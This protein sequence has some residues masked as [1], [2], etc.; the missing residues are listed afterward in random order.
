M[1]QCR[2]AWGAVV[3]KYFTGFNIG[4]PSFITFDYKRVITAHPFYILS[5]SMLSSIVNKT[6]KNLYL[7]MNIVRGESCS[8]FINIISIY[9]RTFSYRTV[10]KRIIFKNKNR[11]VISK[12]E[13]LICM[14]I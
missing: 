3:G 9:K 7:E 2:F 6:I 8:D 14:A 1:S 10:L 4:L 12:G 13:G 5:S 11:K